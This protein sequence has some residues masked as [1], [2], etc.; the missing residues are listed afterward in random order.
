MKLYTLLL[1][2]KTVINIRQISIRDYR[3]RRRRRRPRAVTCEMSSIQKYNHFKKLV[4]HE[5]NNI[6]CFLDN[7]MRSALFKRTTYYIYMSLQTYLFFILAIYIYREIRLNSHKY[8]LIHN[9]NVTAQC[10][11][12]HFFF[13][14]HCRSKYIFFI[15]IIY[16]YI[17]SRSRSSPNTMSTG[18]QV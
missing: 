7:I 1:Y 12:M 14:F 18:T 13:L 10:A 11:L 3:I 17:H 16:Y 9:R 4:I 15:I 6:K 5:I 8:V 2:Y